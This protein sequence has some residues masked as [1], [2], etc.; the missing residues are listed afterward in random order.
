MYGGF[1]VGWKLVM[2]PLEFMFMF[3]FMFMF[4]LVLPPERSN[5]AN[6]GDE[7]ADKDA[8]C[9]KLP[10]GTCGEAV[11]PSIVV[12]VVGVINLSP[13]NGIS[14]VFGAL[15]HDDP[16]LI[17]IGI[18]LLDM[19]GRNSEYPLERFDKSLVDLGGGNIDFIFDCELC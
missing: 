1:N 18:G 5:V 13:A 9:G 15:V 11:Y 8:E 17:F 12:P 4:I 16:E 7:D 10:N 14:P 19:E 3:M 2:L 6:E